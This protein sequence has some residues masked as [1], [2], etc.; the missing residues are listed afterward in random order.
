MTDAPDKIVATIGKNSRELLRVSIT[1][2]RGIKLISLRLWTPTAD[3][4][5]TIPT[6]SG[7]ELRIEKLPELRA[8]IVEAE[9][10]ARAAG[11]LP[12]DSP[13]AK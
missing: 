4:A 5:K 10:Q 11:L 6:R 8:A 2:F 3:G 7:L 1:E 12:T 9:A 13:A